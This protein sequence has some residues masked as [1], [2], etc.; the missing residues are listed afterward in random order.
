M[1]KRVVKVTEGR[2][3]EAG[4]VGPSIWEE[5]QSKDI[6]KSGLPLLPFEKGNDPTVAPAPKMPPKPTPERP[7]ELHAVPSKPS[8]IPK[9][10]TQPG[11]LVE[12]RPAPLKPEPEP[13]TEKYRERQE[14][15]QWEREG[16]GEEFRNTQRE[17]LEFKIIHEERAEHQRLGK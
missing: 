4:A 8:M 12:L 17:C 16:S 6:E 2:W 13:V 3:N 15:E 1:A 14:T 7:V 11:W 9:P 5:E 10:K